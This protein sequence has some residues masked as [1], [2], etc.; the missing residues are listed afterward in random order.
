MEWS[1]DAN[2][3]LFVTADNEL[4]MYDLMGTKVKTLPLYCRRPAS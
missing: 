4:H 3:I 2:Y 1:P